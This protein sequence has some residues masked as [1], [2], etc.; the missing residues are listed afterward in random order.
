MF[1]FGIISFFVLMVF[2][3][4]CIL[5]HEDEV[6]TYFSLTYQ[7]RFEPANNKYYIVKIQDGKESRIMGRWGICTIYYE[8]LVE[9]EVVLERLTNLNTVSTETTEI[10]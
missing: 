8:D 4:I 5:F 2:V 10:K 7:V 9:A 6:K 1:M 3:G